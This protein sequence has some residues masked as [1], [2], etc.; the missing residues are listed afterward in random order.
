MP[1]SHLGT[2]RSKA[3]SEKMVTHRAVP[4]YGYGFAA[5]NGPFGETVLRRDYCGAVG[6]FTGSRAIH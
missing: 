6:I 5:E 2:S 4:A 3:P 1:V